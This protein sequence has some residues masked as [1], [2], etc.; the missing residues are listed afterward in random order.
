MRGQNNMNHMNL[1]V[2]KLIFLV[3]GLAFLTC[4]GLPAWPEDEAGKEELDLTGPETALKSAM[5]E[6]F[7]LIDS[8]E[9]EKGLSEQ[10]KTEKVFNTI[11]NSRW[12]PEQDNYF[13]VIDVNGN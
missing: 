11:K 13:W 9:K 3:M 1:I 6:L 5:D 10:E 12:G 7:S 4:S 8:I 2:K